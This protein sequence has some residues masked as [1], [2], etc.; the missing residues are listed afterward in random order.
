MKTFHYTPTDTFFGATTISIQ[1]S[2]EEIAKQFLH[3]LTRLEHAEAW[4]LEKVDE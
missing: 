1:A 4:Q 2:N 3:R